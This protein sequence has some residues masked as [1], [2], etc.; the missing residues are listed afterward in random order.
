MCAIR[1]DKEL[2]NFDEENE[3]NKVIIT[4]V[5]LIKDNLSHWKAEQAEQNNNNNKN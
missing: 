4:L 3:N 2:P 5:N 1:I